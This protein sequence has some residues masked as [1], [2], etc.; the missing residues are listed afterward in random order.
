MAEEHS[1]KVAPES[2][3]WLSEQSEATQ[4]TIKSIVD[5]AIQRL[6]GKRPSKIMAL[7]LD[8]KGKQ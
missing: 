1:I 5:L 8:K 2:H 7:F 3:R 6:R 4:I